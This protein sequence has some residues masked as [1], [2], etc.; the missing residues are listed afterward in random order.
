MKNFIPIL[1]LLFVLPISINAQN[2]WKIDPVHSSIQFDV[3]HLVVSTVTGKFTEFSG[4]VE[5]KNDSFENAK[6]EANVE[7]KSITTENLTRDN[8]LKEDDFFNA[9]K[10]PQIK[11]KSEYFKKVADNEY[12]LSGDLTIRD[13]T[14][15]VSMKAVHTGSITIGE[16]IVSGFKVNFTVNRFDFN[17]KWDDTLDSGSLV[18][19]E[20]VD[21]KMNLEL[22]KM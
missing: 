21:I 7:V 8:H 18:V 1:L 3:T 15:K 22:I 10:F 12:L 2:K 20:N 16:K 14:K 19:G 9:E 13:V 6:V 17:L 11:F 4:T 5:A